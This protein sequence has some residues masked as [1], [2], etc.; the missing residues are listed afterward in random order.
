MRSGLTRLRRELGR[1]PRET[2]DALVVAI[3]VG[4]VGS[5]IVA[6]TL[7][8]HVPVWALVLGMGLAAALG[9]VRGASGEH[10]PGDRAAA[11]KLAGRTTACFPRT[12]IVP[13]VGKSSAC[14]SRVRL[15]ASPYTRER[16]KRPTI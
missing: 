16:F 2:A 14:Q 9:I 5:P 6:I 3:A 11:S 13:K 7:D 12:A 15:R 8:H 10:G 4:A 1:L